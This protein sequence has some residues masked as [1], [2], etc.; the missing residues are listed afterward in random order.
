MSQ[1]NRTGIVIALIVFIMCIWANL[2][3]GLAFSF[4]WGLGV[5]EFLAFCISGSIITAL[6][7]LGYIMGKF[8]S[9]K[10]F[11]LTRR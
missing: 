7:V 1:L 5:P 4:A 3:N 6:V 9:T 10:T 11:N 2:F 8:I